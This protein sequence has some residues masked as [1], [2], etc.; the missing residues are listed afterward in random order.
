MRL[1]LASHN[2]KKL[3]ELR[4]LFAPLGFEWLSSAELGISEPHE[5]HHTFV[6]N[7]LIKARHAAQQAGCAAIA[8][9]S[10]L[11]VHAL[12]GAPG[13]D[14]ANY[15]RVNGAAGA[16]DREARRRAQDRANNQLLL[17]RLGGV[18]DRRAHFVSALV[19]LRNADDPEPLIAVGRWSGEILAAPRGDSGFGYDPLL[20]IPSLGCSVAEI[21]S[22]VKNRVSHRALAAQRMLLAMREAWPDA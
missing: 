10:G 5:P 12:G 9:D 7:A 3:A 22:D 16:G 21:G 19:A 17:E 15:A 2:A 18:A 4:S 6:E 1:V 14:S 8:D 20:F 11:C 13:V